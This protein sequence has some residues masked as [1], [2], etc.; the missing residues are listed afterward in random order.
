MPA[1]VPHEIWHE[2]QFDGGITGTPVDFDTDTIKLALID[3]TL[4]P[5]ETTHDNW[6]DLSSNEVSGD[7]YTA[8]GE[9]L[10]VTVEKSSAVVTVDSGDT[11]WSQE[12]AGFTNARYAVWYKVGGGESSS[13]ILGHMDMGSDKGNV[14]GPLTI[15]TPNGIFTSTIT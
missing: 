9:T 4:A 5:D 11:T 1:F 7:G 12:A 14:S 6:D 3:D 2:A 15:E 8:G 10:T 13:P